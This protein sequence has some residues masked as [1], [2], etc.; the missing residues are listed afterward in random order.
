MCGEG[1]GE[2]MGWREQCRECRSRER[3]VVRDGRRREGGR[4]NSEEQDHRRRKKR[5]AIKG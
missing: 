5:E 4:L 3:N 1:G 2:K